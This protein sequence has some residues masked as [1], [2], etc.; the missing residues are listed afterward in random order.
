LSISAFEGGGACSPSAMGWP[1]AKNIFSRPAGATETII[2]VVAGHH[3]TADIAD[4]GN[5][6]PFVRLRRIGGWVICVMSHYSRRESLEP[7]APIS[8]G[9]L[10]VAVATWP[11]NRYI[12]F[13]T[14][15]DGGSSQPD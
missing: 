9:R 12:G 6:L 5:D 2:R 8:G 10:L 4:E 7:A 3:E 13:R 11:C 14:I 1:T 15:Q